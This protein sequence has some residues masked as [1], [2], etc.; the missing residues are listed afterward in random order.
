MFTPYFNNLKDSNVE[1]TSSGRFPYYNNFSQSFSP[2]IN[3]KIRFHSLIAIG[4]PIVDIS[5]EITKEILNKYNLQ[6]GQTVFVNATN[7]GFYQE[8]ENMP[9]VTYIPGGSIQNTLRVTA[10]C[11]YM[12]PENIRNFKLTMLGATGKDNYRDKIIN[13]FKDLGVNH[14]LELI[15]NFQTSRCG[16]GIH[17]KERC[18]V[19]EI[20]AS[21]CLSEDFVNQ[22]IEE[23]MSHDVLLIE[24]YFLQEKY[25]LCLNLCN[26]FKD[27]RKLV[28]LT[29]SAITIV[30]QQA[31]K[32]LEIANY[33]DIIAGNLAELE[34]FAEVKN[35][36]YKVT[37]EK[38]SKRLTIKKERIFLITLGSKGA[39][40]AKYDYA[41]GNMDFILQCF[42]TV[43]KKDDIVDLN[44]AGDAFLGG[45]LSQYMQGKNIENCCKA[46]NDTAGV[47][48]KNIGCTFNRKNII[49]FS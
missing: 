26:R 1:M 37:F 6:F 43:I 5:A 42:P 18:L 44:G 4:N 14:I 23:I 36:D 39:I 15:P 34:A 8:L 10:W 31:E 22:N 12:N 46:G 7:V 29:L 20:R 11:L 21:N 24:G 2:N 33:S 41:R 49:Q 45:F 27:Q 40:V 30:Q 25:D 38:A 17:Q 35:M 19:P 3:S 48:L 47:I 28:I 9:K 16:V 13:A 32:I